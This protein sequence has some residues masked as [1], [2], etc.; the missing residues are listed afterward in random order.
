MRAALRI[1]KFWEWDG[2]HPWRELANLSRMGME[3]CWIALWYSDLTQINHPISIWRAVLVLGAL[4]LFS[5]LLA[6]GLN[7]EKQHAA[8]R[9]LVD[10]GVLLFN[11]ALSLELLLYA[12]EWQGP[13]AIVGRIVSGF[14]V[15]NTIPAE[16]WVL[17]ACLLVWNRGIVL[18]RSR[19][20]ADLSLAGFQLGLLMF[21][22]YGSTLAFL[23]VRTALLALAAFLLLGLVSMSAARVYET[24]RGRG[25]RLAG[26]NRVWLG[27]ILLAALLVV[28][29]GIV[30]ASLLPPGAAQFVIRYLL[31]GVGLL[32]GLFVLILAPVALAIL[33]AFQAVWP[34]LDAL[35]QMLQLNEMLARLKGPVQ[36]N[37][38]ENLMIRLPVT[39]PVV[40]VGVLALVVA[41]ILAGLGWRAWRERSVA[42]EDGHIDFAPPDLL[43]LL[44]LF[45][46]KRLDEAREALARGALFS[47]MDR[48]FAAARV[49]WIYARLM[50][51]C[52]KMG[53]PRPVAKTPWE[54]LP[55]L[56]GLFPGREKELG[57]ITQAYVR[58]RYG[59]APETREE[60]E[61]LMGDW[62]E[63]T[64]GK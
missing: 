6:R 5:H 43:R 8:V 19:V 28:A 29:V 9:R 61:R 22:F 13:V 42:Q 63:V 17:L 52:V 39:K 15:M 40:L 1:A 3:L 41:A 51:L 32:A 56:E 58:V 25:G 57:E 54:F 38:L 26:F 11:L 23:P 37:N 44:R 49:R 53:H 10:L 35:L 31:V 7:L 47:R 18:A 55:E 12:P 64:R 20:S 2:I 21:F 4:E 30:P 24:G 50:R 36:G 33:F 60:V 48:L 34:K 46:R 62:K 59:E 27:G 45:M 14:S 16:F